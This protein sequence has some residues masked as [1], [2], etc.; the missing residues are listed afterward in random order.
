[1]A[2]AMTSPSLYQSKYQT[3]AGKRIAPRDASGKFRTRVG[4]GGMLLWT[5]EAVVE[6][7]TAGMVL[8]IKD[9]AD[10]AADYARAEHPWNNVSGDLEAGIW[11]GDPEI[12]GATIRCSWGAPSPAIYLELGT[13]KMPAYP[14]LRPAADHAYGRFDHLILP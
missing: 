10:T 13:S 6:E 4:E 14:F 7:L 12:H 2:S 8:L 3:S 5:G 1:M 11:S 9:R